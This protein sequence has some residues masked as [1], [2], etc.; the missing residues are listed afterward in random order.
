MKTKS[1]AFFTVLA[2]TGI[3]FG[4]VGISRS[5]LGKN[6]PPQPGPSLAAGVS[7][8]RGR[9]LIRISGCNDCHTPGFMQ[10]PNVPESEWLVGSSMGW[11]GPWGTTYPSNLRRHLA[12]WEDAETWIAMVRSRHGLPPMPWPSLHAMDDDE[13]NSIFAYIRSLP[14]TGD[15]MPAPVPPAREPTTPY[16]NLEPVMPKGPVARR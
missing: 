6:H 11:R 7:V 8:E 16:L 13:L 15:I 14:V 3:L 9:H 12:A 5:L 4:A 10:N 1:D 2:C